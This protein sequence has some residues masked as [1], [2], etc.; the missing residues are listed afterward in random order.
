[1]VQGGGGSFGITTDFGVG[2]NGN[3]V[4][5]APSDYG[6]SVFAPRFADNFSL[7][8]FQSS[9]SSLTVYSHVIGYSSTVTPF[10]STIIDIYSGR[11][12]DV[13]SSIIASSSNQISS[14]FSSVYRTP[15]NAVTDASR[16]V[17]E[18]TV[19]FTDLTLGPGTYW[20]SFR[21]TANS[22]GNI[23]V[24]GVTN[25]TNGN[26]QIIPGNAL[27]YDAANNTW[28]PLYHLANPQGSNPNAPAIQME[29]PF[30]VNGTALQGPV[31]PEPGTLLLAALPAI[32]AL[33]LRL[34]RRRLRH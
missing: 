1:V 31:A 18:S 5:Q 11:P 17:F 10:T 21:Q 28:V 26:I 23:D 29:L 14:I 2:F 25:K 27:G 20:F 13:G 34:R 7:T 4:S 30:L 22:P 6:R 8:G 32:G 9:I 15:F 12:G 33:A 24:S 19:A 3:D 16:P